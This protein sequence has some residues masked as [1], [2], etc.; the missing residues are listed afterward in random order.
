MALV[1]RLMGLASDGVSPAPDDDPTQ[2]KIPVHAFFAAQSEIINGRMTVA[3][4]KNYLNMDA[5]AQTEYD[6]LIATAPAG[7]T[8]LALA[9]KALFIESIHAVFMLAE[10]G[11][12]GYDT[13]A[14]VRSKLG[15]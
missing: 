9:Q 1:E 13:P 10:I 2:G 8:A 14:N 5:A 15:I 4:V 12:P 6:S 11:A 7:T 3:G